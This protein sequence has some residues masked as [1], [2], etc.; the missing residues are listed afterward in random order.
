[1]MSSRCISPRVG[2]IEILRDQESAS[3]LGASPDGSV[4]APGESFISHGIDVVA[5]PG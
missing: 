5:E 4:I 3:G 1:M 2:K